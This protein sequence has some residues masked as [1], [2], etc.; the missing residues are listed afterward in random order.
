[1]RRAKYKCG[2]CNSEFELSFFNSQDIPERNVGCT[3]CRIAG[4][5]VKLIKKIRDERCMKDF[6]EKI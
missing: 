3:N 4:E 2:Y 5:K 1:M 6:V